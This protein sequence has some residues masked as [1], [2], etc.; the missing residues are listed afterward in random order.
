MRTDR[1]RLWSAAAVLAA[2]VAAAAVCSGA[3]DGMTPGAPASGPGALQTTVSGAGPAGENDDAAI[4]F[5]A[6][7]EQNGDI[8]AWIRIPGTGVDYPVLQK[9]DSTDPYDNYYLDHTVDLKEGYPG[10]VYSHAVNATDFGDPVTVLYGHNMKDGSMFASLHS[11]EEEAFFEENRMVYVW[12]PE[13]VL[14][15][16]IFA[17]VNF[18][19]TLITY[20][21]DFSREEEV[22]RY[23]DDIGGCAGNVSE[24][25]AVTEEDRI[26][27]LSTCYSDQEFNRLLIEAV[28][29]EEKERER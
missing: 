10:A 12:T 16:E 29:V 8:H 6:L 19:D 7:R 11:Y 26:L 9:R 14:T 28:L 15:Y 3:G 18:P 17:A 25:C 2:A 24:D 27:T 20:E 13:A 4:D 22:G 1:K 23:L 21:Y 5:D